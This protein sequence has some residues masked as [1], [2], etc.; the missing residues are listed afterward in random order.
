VCKEIEDIIGIDA[1]NALGVSAKTGIGVDELLEQIIALI[2]EPEGDLEA[3][4]QALI[5]DSW[6]DSYLGVVSLV[7]V[8]NGIM[9]QGDR[10]L[11]MSTNQAYNSIK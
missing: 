8:K 2:P 4:L 9:R 7:R 1:K 3:P 5:I 11:V 10:I 6:F